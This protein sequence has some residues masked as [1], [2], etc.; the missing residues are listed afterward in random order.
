V[1]AG[2]KS[3]QR[4]SRERLVHRDPGEWRHGPRDG[5]GRICGVSVV[6][7]AVPPSD[8]TVRRAGQT[9]GGYAARCA[10]F[11]CVTAPRPDYCAA[12]DTT[13]LPADPQTGRRL[14]HRVP[15]RGRHPTVPGRRH[16]LPPRRRQ[17]PEAGGVRGGAGHARPAHRRTLPA[18]GKRSGG[19]GGGAPR[20]ALARLDPGHVRAA[21]PLPAGAVPTRGGC[22][23]NTSP[24]SPPET[25][26]S[27]TTA[28]PRSG[29]RRGSGPSVRPTTCRCAGLA[30][31]PGG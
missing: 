17:L 27:R 28:L 21:G 14:P 12:T 25:S 23:T 19:G 15:R 10:D 4:R 30:R 1:H 3:R 31:S 22:R 5:G 9:V 13:P 18:D 29:R 7:P 16:R 8:G 20:A 11:G 6:G 26:L 24:G 2:G